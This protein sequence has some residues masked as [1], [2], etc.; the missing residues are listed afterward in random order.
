MNMGKEVFFVFASKGAI[1]RVEEA[2]ENKSKENNS[3]LE[4]QGY[5]LSTESLNNNLEERVWI[6]EKT[7]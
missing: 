3:F 6:F 5:V 1:K 4:E 7:T 2:I